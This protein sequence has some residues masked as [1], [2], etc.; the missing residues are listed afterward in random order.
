MEMRQQLSA[1]S[2]HS[3]YLRA[4]ESVDFKQLKVRFDHRSG[5]NTHEDFTKILDPRKATLK[6]RYL[7]ALGPPQ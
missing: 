1:E 6:W 5:L 2:A 4:S 3:R 7:H